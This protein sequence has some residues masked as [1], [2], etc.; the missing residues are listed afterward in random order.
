M[1]DS[2]NSGIGLTTPKKQMPK[3]LE[4]PYFEPRRKRI[5]RS[6]L[7]WK[8]ADD[9]DEKRSVEAG[10]DAADS[11]FNLLPFT[12]IEQEIQS[13]DEELS[14]K[15]S[16]QEN[17]VDQKRSNL[18]YEI[19]FVGENK[20]SDT[21]ATAHEDVPKS[22][23]KVGAEECAGSNQP[24]IPT[25]L[26]EKSTEDLKLNFDYRALPRLSTL[27]VI[28]KYEKSEVDVSE[29]V[30]RLRDAEVAVSLLR[31]EVCT[32][33]L[34]IRNLRSSMEETAADN[35]KQMQKI[36]TINKTNRILK[37]NLVFIQE[38]HQAERN[39][40][41]AA[42]QEEVVG[43]IARAITLTDELNVLHNEETTGAYRRCSESARESKASQAELE[44]YKQ[45]ARELVKRVR[46]EKTAV[47]L[48]Y[49]IKKDLE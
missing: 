29:Y 25:H 21:A 47:E 40:S 42:D 23:H 15:L 18:V 35:K 5:R 39:N 6:S 24:K 9:M 41:S 36:C 28:A 13:K 44:G 46:S 48:I 3:Q 27:D 7:L 11:P 1:D 34:E 4:S 8:D 20:L 10:S 12:D 43:L 17:A 30:Q 19:D 33:D 49:D 14:K 37:Q 26:A 45:I 31:R 2:D 32:K 38:K 22:V 16:R